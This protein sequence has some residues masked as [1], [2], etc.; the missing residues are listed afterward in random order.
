MGRFIKHPAIRVGMSIGVLTS[1]MAL[2]VPN[3][4]ALASPVVATLSG[5]LPSFAAQSGTVTVFAEPDM[6]QSAPGAT[7][8]LTE[9][10]TQPTSGPN[11]TIPIPES[12]QLSLMAPSSGSGVV[13]VVV[14]VKSQGQKTAET[15][16]IPTSPSA[17]T[18]AGSSAPTA[19]ASATSNITLSTFPAPW[20]SSVA[21]TSHAKTPKIVV[22]GCQA[23]TLQ[24]AEL[25]SRIGELHV[26]NQ[27]GMSARYYYNTIADSSITSGIS[28]TYGGSW[29]GAGSVTVSNSL[30]TSGSL[31]G[32][33]GYYWY[34]NSHVY[35]G[36]YE[37][38]DPICG[39]FYI[40]QA[41][42]AVG[43]V[44]QGTNKP[45]TNPW[46][47]C[48]S[49]PNGFATVSAHGGTYG[50]QRQTSVNYSGIASA[51]GFTFGGST[52]YSTTN[53][54]TYT[55]SGASNSYVCGS[56]TPNSSPILYNSPT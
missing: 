10:A 35:Y 30:S 46:G 18:G 5:I 50:T 14:V 23:I 1:V 42:N 6:T 25:A 52:G 43:D 4:G 37:I 2:V 48:G 31:T 17:T 39:A 29:S 11:F 12:S 15:A 27:T 3:A 9:I 47:S 19:G 22:D 53:G 49:D 28:Q 32:T 55:D 20:T 7:F 54:I 21:V 38:A 34:M 40:T 51:F 8:T 44:F 33:A 26:A 13:N 45:G 16:T 56:S 36:Y 24:T 41:Y